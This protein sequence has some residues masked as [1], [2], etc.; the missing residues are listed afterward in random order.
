MPV[1]LGLAPA[2]S[3]CSG[4]LR[5]FLCV[6]SR[7]DSGQSPSGAGGHEYVCQGHFP[8]VGLKRT[9]SSWNVRDRAQQGGGTVLKCAVPWDLNS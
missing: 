7:G 4:L 9:V 6:R 3:R 1:P 5:S 2:L 8:G